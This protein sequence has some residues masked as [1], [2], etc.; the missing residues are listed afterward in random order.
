[1]T[2]VGN[3]RLR[4]MLVGGEAL[5]RQGLA[6]L[7][8][9]H[10]EIEVVGVAVSGRTA[11]AKLAGYQPDLVV[12]DMASAPQE[13]IELF[14][15]L[16]GHREGGVVGVAIAS[17]EV[18]SEEQRRITDLGVSTIVRRHAGAVTEASVA[19]IAQDILPPLLRHG[20]RRRT[21]R[22][23]PGER[24]GASTATAVPAVPSASHAAANHAAAGPAPGA[25]RPLAQPPKLTPVGH[26]VPGMRTPHVVG[27]GVSTGGP[28]ALANLLPHLPATF[29]LPIVIVQHMP[30]KFTA[31]LAESLAKV[32]QLAVREAAEGEPVKRGAILI[33][34]GG[35]HM[36]IERRDGGEFVKLTSDP[37][38]CSCRPSVDYL[39]RSLV[40][41]YGGRTLGVMLTG[42]G[43]DGWIGS[44]QIYDAG[45]CV[46]AQDEATS[47]VFGMPR[48]PV[49]A[50][51]ALGFPL[52]ELPAAIESAARGH[53]CN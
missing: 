11:L 32:C 43:E 17:D 14:G 49:T 5:L 25:P 4:V 28:K 26:R 3:A 22:P 29:P 39:F 53:S 7:L 35:F 47:T 37:P 10:P 6:R 24:A 20:S 23:A 18:G 52:G 21:G 19:L 51:I 33:A 40:R 38:E 1:M 8:G 46:L 27:I 2:P 13:A 34:P 12:V 30:P 16:T 45:G 50:G 9:E 44:R 31:S 48:G 15:H 41:T 42:M 36:A